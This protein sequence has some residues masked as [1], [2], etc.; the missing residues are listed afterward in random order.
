M[1]NGPGAFAADCGAAFAARFARFAAGLAVV[2]VLAFV[3]M[4]N[5]PLVVCT[6][7]FG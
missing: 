2:F 5:A 6:G 3:A 1:A 4:V 7:D